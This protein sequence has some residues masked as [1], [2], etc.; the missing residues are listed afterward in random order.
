MNASFF[1]TLLTVALAVVG[2]GGSTRSGFSDG[3][4]F[5]LAPPAPAAPTG[6]GRATANAALDSQQWDVKLDMQPGAAEVTERPDSWT[7]SNTDIATP[8]TG[9]FLFM[10]LRNE[11]LSGASARSVA[12]VLRDDEAGR[13]LDV[14]D[15]ADMEFMGLPGAMYVSS[16]SEGT[17]NITVL[18]ISNNCVY[19]L[20]VTRS[21]DQDAVASY[22]GQLVGMIKTY[23]GGPAN[24]PA[25]R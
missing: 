12:G 5:G 19:V 13:G 10:V 1:V 22:F 9:Q 16:G 2:C 15:I 6:P 14:T 18:G 20:N 11:N 8:A 4:G 17:F 7:A 23:T 21:G 3:R 25:C 24:A